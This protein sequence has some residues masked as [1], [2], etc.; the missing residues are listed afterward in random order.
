[1]SSIVALGDLHCGHVAGLTPPGSWTGDDRPTLRKLESLMYEK[2]RGWVEKY[3]RPEWLFVMGDCTDGKGLRSGG[4]ELLVAD[5]EDQAAMA[6]K[7]LRMWEAENIVM[8]YGTPY[9]TSSGSG[10]DIENY[11]ARELGAEIKS[12]AQVKID[13]LVFDLKH[14]ISGSGIPHGKHTSLAK[15]RMHNVDW[16]L[17][18]EQ[19]ALADVFL[20]GHTHAYVE[21][22]GD[23]G[24]HWRGII[25]PA[26][27]APHTKYGGRQCEGKVA[28]GLHYM[29]INGGEFLEWKTETAKLI[30][31]RDDLITKETFTT[32]RMISSLDQPS[33]LSSML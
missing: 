31:Y 26:L 21:D 32:K 9:H 11:I 2:Y 23:F 28:F 3:K 29:N 20:R 14:K 7:L 8:V 33:S 15:A 4:C 10:E 22:Q 17:D 13:G 5:L 18:G 16:Y 19:Q 24:G 30:N 1:M 27:Q 25:L 6:V 12:H